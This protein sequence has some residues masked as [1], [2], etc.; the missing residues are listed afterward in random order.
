MR[1][2]A[3]ASPALRVSKGRMT[4][5]MPRA[6]RTFPLKAMLKTA[7]PEAGSPGLLRQTGPLA[8]TSQIL[9]PGSGPAGM[10]PTRWKAVWT[11]VRGGQLPCRYLHRDLRPQDG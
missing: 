6:S 10:D 7:L 1:A 8:D 3:P 11:D 4:A 2:P 5:K 9:A